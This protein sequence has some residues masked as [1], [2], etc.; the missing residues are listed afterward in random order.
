MICRF[1]SNGSDD[2]ENYRVGY[3]KISKV[4]DCIFKANK[5]YDGTLDISRDL[6]DICIR[7]CNGE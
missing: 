4:Y 5:P 1:G 6:R 7:V 2:D 3:E